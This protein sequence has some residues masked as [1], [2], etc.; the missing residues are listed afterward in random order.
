MENSMDEKEIE[1]AI[2]FK[3]ERVAVQVR[4]YLTGLFL[5]ASVIGTLTN[6]WTIPII[7]YYLS[8]AYFFVL[9]TLSFFLLKYRK[10]PFW[11]IYFSAVSDVLV[12]LIIRIIT[13]IFTDDGLE[14]EM[15]GKGIFMIFLIFA[16][17]MPLRNNFRFSVIIG[18][19]IFLAEI[20]FLAFASNQGYVYAM[21][22]GF[23]KNEMNLVSLINGNL[24]FLGTI[25]ILC[26]ATK[27]M[28]TYLKESRANESKARNTNEKNQEILI[29]LQNSK[30]QIHKLKDFANEFL[31]EL[32]KG[33]ETQASTSEESSAAMEEIS[34]A[35]R[36]ISDTTRE[37]QGQ[38]LSAEKQATVLQLEF[39]DFKNLILRI[40]ESIKQLNID[41]DKG[42]GVIQITKSSMS[43]INQSAK[44]IAGTL[45]V[46]NELASRTN[47]LALNASIE[48]ARAG[49]EGKGFAVVAD[50]VSKLASRSTNHTKEIAEKIN[51]S[52]EKT[53]DGTQSVFEVN[54]TFQNIF[55]GFSLIDKNLDKGLESLGIF[56]GEKDKIIQSIQQLSEQAHFVRD[57]TKEQSSA[58]DATNESINNLSQSAAYLSSWISKFDTLHLFLN[59]TEELIN[60]INTE[61]S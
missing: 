24:F 16:A 6:G 36:K 53:E 38:V 2:T 47:L 30:D 3:G 21:D 55:D 14:Q 32:Q 27:I 15:K 41:L 13:S 1:Q 9:T 56:E 7:A 46:M 11:M 40:K 48:A 8:T 50:E 60:K 49:E 58:I 29:G 4:F 10:L 34:A 45:K 19:L 44:D 18:S 35:S 43:N 28:N 25:A 23:G 17:L 26:I 22:N 31:S 61:E 33:L 20:A 57:S 39:E 37:Q 52:L 5:L 42:R 59:Q 54:E 12:V 51:H